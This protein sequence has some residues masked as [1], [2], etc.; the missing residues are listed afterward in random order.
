M[1]NKD[2]RIDLSQ[3]NRNRKMV[4]EPIIIEPTFLSQLFKENPDPVIAAADRAR[5]F[6]RTPPS[7]DNN[8]S[9]TFT[10]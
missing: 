3:Y 6:G 2:N 1:N 4:E 8:Q 7:N 10:K 5:R 9:G